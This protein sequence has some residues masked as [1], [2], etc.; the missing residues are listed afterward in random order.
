MRALRHLDME[1]RWLCLAHSYEFTDR[2]DDFSNEAKLQADK[3]PSLRI[4]ST[5]FLWRQQSHPEQ[6]LPLL[7]APLPTVSAPKRYVVVPT[8][9]QPLDRYREVASVNF[10]PLDISRRASSARAPISSFSHS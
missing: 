4:S 1:R 8:F 2:L 3:L 10:C 9:V 5:I 6:S 7:V